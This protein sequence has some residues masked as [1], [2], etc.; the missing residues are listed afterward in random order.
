MAKDQRVRFAALEAIMTLQP[1]KPYAGSSYVAETLLWFA[2]ANG[3]RVLVVAHPKLADAA[4][5]AGFFIGCGYQA[6]LAQTCRETMQLAAK[7]PDTELVVV[8]LLTSEP[9]VSEFAQ[10]MRNDAR[11]ANIPIAILT[12]NEKI[13]E[14]APNNQN[15]TEMQNIDQLQPNAPF[16]FALTQTYPRIVSE[17]GATWLNND[18][19]EKTAIQPVPTNIRIQQA[20]KSLKW[21]KITLENAQNG[22]KLY[23]FEGLESAVMNALRS[24]GRVAEGLE[25][26]ATVKSNSLQVEIYETAANSLQTL[27]LRQNAANAFKKSV[28]TFG[29]LLR[30][31]QVQRL[32]DRYNASEFEPKESQELL[33]NLID[34]LE[35]KINNEGKNP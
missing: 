20:K 7:T 24:D 21:I 18:L 15:R 17:D 10:E 30:G 27:Q 34:F 16:S 25:L 6:E 19:F 8:D 14:S 32:Y 3:Q 11:T 4:K 2:H 22:R 33:E 23:H 13:L 35:E 12:N 26:A 28:Q 31:Q 1:E 29:V 9:S 5:T